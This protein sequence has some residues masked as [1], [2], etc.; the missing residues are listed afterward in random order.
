MHW[1]T[2]AM[3][4]PMVCVTSDESGPL[5]LRGIIGGTSS[6]YRDWHKKYNLL[7]QLILIPQ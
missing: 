1:I 3:N 5:G 2:R 7:S 6:L 4:C